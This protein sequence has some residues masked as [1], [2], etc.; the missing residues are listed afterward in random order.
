MYRN[1]IRQEFFFLSDFGSNFVSRGECC[2]LAL[3]LRI[4]KKEFLYTNHNYLIYYGFE[5]DCVTDT[6]NVIYS[7]SHMISEIRIHVI[8]KGESLSMHFFNEY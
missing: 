3:F 7:Y 8:P 2:F 5:F 1:N 6:V 4:F